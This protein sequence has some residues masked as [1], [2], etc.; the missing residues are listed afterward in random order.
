MFMA[1]AQSLSFFLSHFVENLMPEIFAERS[2]YGDFVFS[3]G[4][5]RD[6]PVP[7]FFLRCQP[8]FDPCHLVLI[9][10]MYTSLT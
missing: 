9:P 10:K 7:K 5:E 6:T 2:K 4:F 1:D 3:L 8:L